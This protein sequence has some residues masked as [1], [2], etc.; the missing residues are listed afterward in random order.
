M[1]HD[2]SHEPSDPIGHK[3]LENH[4]NVNF[5][6]IILSIRQHYSVV[7]GAG[8]HALVALGGTIITL[9]KSSAHLVRAGEAACVALEA[10]V[11][12]QEPQ[13]VEQLHLAESG[14]TLGRREVELAPSAA[15]VHLQLSR[16][17][18]REAEGGPGG[19]HH[20]GAQQAR[21]GVQESRVLQPD[22][23]EVVDVLGHVG[24][25]LA[26]VDERAAVVQ[27]GRQDGVGQE[28]GGGAVRRGEALETQ[29]YIVMGF[30][31]LTRFH[32]K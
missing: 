28:E 14:E 11:G 27:V 22:L 31:A 19:R 32:W 1:A 13:V 12:Q 24:G 18:G 26:V 29:V 25:G 17:H 5:T 3:Y 10:V 30:A 23:E 15:A 2:A 9:P 21:A 16:P 8:G 7:R 4:K 20:G 6:A